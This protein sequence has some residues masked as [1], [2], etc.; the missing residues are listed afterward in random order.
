M[1]EINAAFGLLQLEHMPHVMQRRAEIDASTA[2]NWPMCQELPAYP[3]AT[4]L[5]PTIHTFRFLLG[6]NTH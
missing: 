6:L 1:S 3:K 4:R 2:S 5:W